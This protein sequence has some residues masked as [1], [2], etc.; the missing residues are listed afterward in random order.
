MDHGGGRARGRRG[1]AAA[2]VLAL[3]V[4]CHD[5]P[6]DSSRA[7]GLREPLGQAVPATMASCQRC[8]P[9]EVSAYLGH[10]M[11]HSMGP[12]DHVPS[13]ELSHPAT[14]D[15]YVFSEQ[16]G[17]VF[18]HALRADGGVRTQAVV[19]R[20]GAG[21]FDTSYVGTE[22]LPDGSPSGRLS[23]L[24]L[25]S[26]AGHGLAL[27]P[28]EAM[29][30]RTG[31]DMPLATECLQCHTTADPSALP[32]ASVAREGG[33]VWPG[34]QLGA[35]AWEH[36]PA[37]GCD[38]CHGPTARH[39]ELK[40]ES[41]RT[42]E[43]SLELGLERLGALP[44]RR[45]VDICSRCH[46]QGEGHLFLEP[47]EPGG[48]QPDDFTMRRP[49]FVPAEPG[50]DFRFVG[51]V[52]RLSLSEC[53]QQSPELTCTSCHDP[54]AAAAAQGTAAFDARC[55][56][57]HDGGDDCVRP[58]S[59][60]VRE[61][62]RASARSDDGCVDCHVRRSQPFDLPHVRTADHF[63][64]R[65]IPAPAAPP[66]R[67][68]EAEGGPLQVYRD[69]R[70]DE[71]LESSA[72]ERWEQAALGAM[73]TRMGQR[74][75]AAA[76]FELLAAPGTAGAKVSS[77]PPG[78][79]GLERSADLHLMRGLLLEATGDLA[80]AR[81]AYGD[82]LHADDEHPQARLN[83]AYLAL[84][85]GEIGAAMADV[86]VLAERHPAAEKVWNLRALAAGQAGQLPS[87]I[88]ALMES[89]A[90]WPSDATTWHEAGRLM[91]QLGDVAGAR[92]MLRHAVRLDPSRPGL[93]QDLEAAGG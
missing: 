11:A 51:Q 17:A 33:P 32:G 77:A 16:R 35:D 42:R 81:A 36:L 78:L 83:R 59:L 40:L 37:L 13:G 58:P 65:H 89:A 1:A 64:R 31:F 8:H 52:H 39:A 10:G 44:A 48:P 24:P 88:G 63:V 49:V 5:E 45:Q 91:L 19:G 15:R 85:A 69:E 84:Q 93:A 22:L 4:G 43:P 29:E 71:L 86:D 6:G 41:M 12:L 66:L 50:D 30:P 28:F 55:V 56:T 54:H 79:P 68:W 7:E 67:M 72:G 25:E 18:L 47:V 61:V 23:F 46:L 9:D 14:S 2:L 80:G 53:F 92:E 3:L 74:E 70:H 34:S 60:S 73:F 62:T 21:I 75:R 90:R 20:Y 82:A 87:A 27:S 57:C 38:T 26:V 76:A